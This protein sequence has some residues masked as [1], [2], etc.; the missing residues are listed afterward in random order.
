[1]NESKKMN[2]DFWILSSVFSLAAIVG[3]VANPGNLSPT[4]KFMV[5][6]V[7]GAG[8]ACLILALVILIKSKGKIK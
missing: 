2:K 5:G 8:L 4:G 1:M 3:I 7:L 6:I